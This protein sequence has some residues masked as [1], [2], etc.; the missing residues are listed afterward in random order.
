MDR[1]NSFMYYEN[2]WKTLI[3]QS[4]KFNQIMLGSD[5]IKSNKERYSAV[6]RMVNDDIP[7]FVIGIIHL[8]EANCNFNLNLHNGQPYNMKTTLVPKGRGPFQTWEYSAYD[9]LDMK[10]SILPMIWD[11]ENIGNF[12][13]KYNGMGYKNKGVNSPYLWSFSNHG[14]GV[15]KYVEDEIYDPYAVSQQTGSMVIL[16]DMVNRNIVEIID[17]NSYK[18]IISYGSKDKYI[19]KEFQIF[20]NSVLEKIGE[21]ERLIEDGLPGK[22]TSLINFLVF[23]QYLKGDPRGKDF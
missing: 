18:P 5:I 4:D 17:R 21:E 23:G 14:I 8:M 9:A 19:A 16:K 12:F 10:R 22:K 7:W 2:L 1:E 20:L 6:Q 13:E 3:I 11:I 15:G